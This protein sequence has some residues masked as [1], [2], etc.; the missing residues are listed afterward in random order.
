MSS[1]LKDEQEFARR[2]VQFAGQHV[3]RWSSCEC[4]S[5]SGD[6]GQDVGWTGV[7]VLRGRGLDKAGSTDG[8]ES[9]ARETAGKERASL[10]GVF[11]PFF[12]SGGP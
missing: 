12:S 9:M 10:T 7:Q 1:N 11:C 4:M 5:C 6:K 3:Q 2:E 8:A